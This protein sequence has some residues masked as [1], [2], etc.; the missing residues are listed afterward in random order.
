MLWDRDCCAEADEFP[1]IVYKN[2]RSYTRDLT[3]PERLVTLEYG[4]VILNHGNGFWRL[5]ETFDHR[6]LWLRIKGR[7]DCLGEQFCAF[8]GR[9]FKGR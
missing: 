9:L 5:I 2:N 3:P 4:E 8:Y 6:V 1:V 7:N